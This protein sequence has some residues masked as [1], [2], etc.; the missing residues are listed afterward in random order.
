MPTIIKRCCLAAFF[1]L[2]I[3]SFQILRAQHPRERHARIRAAVESKDNAAATA[4]LQ[5]LLKAD[6]ALFMLNNY[7]YLLGRISERRGDM[8]TAA[9]S[10]QAV[11]ARN[12]LLSQYALWHLS[13]F[14]RSIGN[15]T[16]EREQLRQLIL[17]TPSSLLREAATA[18]LGES[19]FESGD[20]AS[21]IQTLRPHSD[22]KGSA[23]KR[24]ALA[25]VGQA[26]LRAGQQ[27]AARDTF[28]SLVSQTPDASRPDDY[29]L[30]GVRGLDLLDSKSPEAA[31]T[32]APQLSESEHQRRAAIYTFNRDFA[33]ARLHYLAIVERYPNSANVP[34]ALFQTGRGYAQDVQFD[35][36]INYFQRIVKEFPESAMA[37]DALSSLASAYL[38]GKR[39]G[40][41]VTAFRQLIERYPGASNPERYYLNLI[42]ALREA[43]RDS[44]A[45]SWVRQ[46]RDKF[47]GQAAALALFSQTRIHLSQG[48]WQSALADLDALKGEADPGGTR[49][50]GGTTPVEISFLRAY[51]LEQLGR[52]EE[53]VNAYLALPDGRSE[54][55]GGRATRR[56][57]ALAAD[58][59]AKNVIQSRLDSL[60]AEAQQAL[61]GGQAERARMAAQS[62]LRLTE[63]T[64]VTEQLLDIARRA[65]S[66]LP[67][68]N[69]VPTFR[70]LPTG[71]QEVITDKPRESSAA[72]PTHQALADELLFLGL[73]DE[74]A[75]ELAVAENAFSSRDAKVETKPAAG[76]E[77]GKAPETS[78]QAAPSSTPA[79][80]NDAA[81]TLAVLF[82]RGEKADHAIRFAEPL[83]KKVPADYLL[84]LAPREMVEL[85]YP[86]PYVDAL[87]EYAPPRGVDPRFVL[88][89]MRQES[90]FRADAKSISAARGLLQFIPTTANKIAAELGVQNFRQDELYNPRIAVLFGSQ[91]MGNL[92][93]LFPNM[94]Q[95]V[96]ASYNGGEDNVARWVAR[97][98][99][100]DPDR[101]T[102]EIGYTQSKDYVFKVL[103]NY[104]VYQKLYGDQLQ[105][106]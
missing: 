74:G 53:A 33:G 105:P 8:A 57:R 70:L 73:Y 76:D 90:R 78:P 44:E 7:D 86:A 80:S 5:A 82:K 87:R 42:D 72:A 34:E 28:N 35:E 27:A 65:Y 15:L 40:E 20:Y 55:Y 36:A 2:C 91:Y 56:L 26:Y 75:P 71:R 17:T 68:Y 25:L 104:W 3:S 89:I 84:E 94:P 9:A 59:R 62:A 46:T 19:F 101:Y 41:A 21:A 54:Y 39:A 102:I 66:S 4:E 23:A 45:L 58:A 11:A 1:L 81:Y 103:P 63:D 38:R 99:S 51:T 29:A 92:F 49:A 100:E 43:G 85:L 12:S 52:F 93:K 24:E 60:R 10:F 96:A 6:P 98:R 77:T 31:Q 95:A 22:A 14:A 47:K 69:R 37:R 64:A 83:W 18:R 97:A 13:Q 67:A 88:A 106:R 61:S 50:A 48:D 30:A 32:Q 79:R 16:L